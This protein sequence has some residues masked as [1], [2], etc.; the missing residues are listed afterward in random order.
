[1]GSHPISQELRKKEMGCD[2]ISFN[3]IKN[4]HMKVL[5][6]II[7]MIL[8]LGTVLTQSGQAAEATKESSQT[9]TTPSETNLPTVNQIDFRRP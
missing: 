5:S 7:S 9:K 6:I 2:P 8:F 4:L 1:M 3:K